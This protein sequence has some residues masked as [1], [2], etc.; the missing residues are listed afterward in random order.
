MVPYL[1]MKG[2]MAGKTAND[3]PESSHRKVRISADADFED[4]WG[5]TTSHRLFDDGRYQPQADGSYKVTDRCGLGAGVFDVTTGERTFCCLR[6][7]DAEL[8]VPPQWKT[9]HRPLYL[10]YSHESD[11]RST[12]RT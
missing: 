10:E 11:S 7:F 1:L 8:S 12:R 9:D 3:R 2:I 5:G 6:V 4:D